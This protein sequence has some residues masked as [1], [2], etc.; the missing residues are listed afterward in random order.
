[1]KICNVCN[2]AKELSEFHKAKGNRDGYR[3]ECKKCRS[4][5]G[6]NRYDK[7]TTSKRGSE[8]YTAIN[9]RLTNEKRLV[10]RE[11]YRNVKNLMTREEFVKWYVDNY[12]VG[13]TVDRKDNDGDYEINNIQML[14]KTEH[15][16]KKRLDRLGEYTLKENVP[17][18]ICGTVK[19]YTQ[20]Y[21]SNI[22][23]NKYNPYGIRSDCKKCNTK[24]KRNNNEN[25]QI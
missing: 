20:F 19:H 5:N 6:K 21:S 11:R 3:K 8:V 24:H 16:N 13:C 12:F 2:T 14:S 1:M 7:R 15:N 23:I 17:C 18:S 10:K 22:G 25:I 9:D 4:I